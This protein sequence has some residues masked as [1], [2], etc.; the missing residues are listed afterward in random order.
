MPALALNMKSLSPI[1]RDIWTAFLRGEQMSLLQ[2]KAV[3]HSYNS[4]TFL[5]WK[6]PSKKYS[7]T[8]PSPLMKE[9]V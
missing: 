1:C 8:F 3:T 7:L 2:V 9:H 4:H 6:E 5:K